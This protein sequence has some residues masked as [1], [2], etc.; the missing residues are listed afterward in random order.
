MRSITSLL[1]WWEGLDRPLAK[2]PRAGALAIL[3][4]LAAA[5][6]WAALNVSSIDAAGEVPSVAAK[7]QASD[8]PQKGD[9]ALY[10]RI[11][12][13]V[14]SGEN[15]YAAA[16]AEQEAGN[17]PTRPFVTV[18]QP[19]LA[20]MQALIGLEG[21]RIAAIGLLLA[22]LAAFYARFADRTVLVERA[23]GLILIVIG[24]IAATIPVAGL[25]HEI[26]AGLLL[27]FAFLAYDPKRYW[28]SLLAAGLAIAIRE[29][30][31]PF[32]LL[33]FA[34][35]AG[36]SRWREAAVVAVLIACFG[37]GMYCH[38]LAVDAHTSAS[39]PVSQ[40]WE[41]LAG[42]GLPLAALLELT[43]LQAVPPAIA[44]PLALLPLLGWAGLGGRAG[45]F[46]VLWC[47][48]ISQRSPYSHGPRTFT[49]SR[50]CCQPISSAS[51]LRQGHSSS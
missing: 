17:Y 38:Y 47:L 33:W 45:L 25:V 44:A 1:N 43:F 28:P 18:R 39:S 41:A 48:G 42:Y 6:V 21:L 4:V 51:S 24:G 27:T 23:G 31:V 22:S 30:S 40:G 16:V 26:I 10:R 12:E 14:S 19:T 50:L 34:Y 9:L 2:L 11:S 3:A 46:A 32:V 35:S 5:M 49:G 8:G 20:W 15:Y 29:I 36:Q 37:L 7:A 13:R